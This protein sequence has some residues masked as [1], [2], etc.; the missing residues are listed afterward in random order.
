MILDFVITDEKWSRGAMIEEYG[1]KI[2]IVRGSL[3]KDG[4]QYVDWGYPQKN[5]EPIEKAI[6]WKVELGSREEAI[7]MLNRFL[8]VLLDGVNQKRHG[9]TM[10]HE[11]PF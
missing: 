8:S 1:G 7:E 5:K 10:D 4:N 3:G 2:S 6:P 11:P 9:F